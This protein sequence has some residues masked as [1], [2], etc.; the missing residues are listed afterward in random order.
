MKFTF[1]GTGT[2]QGVPVIACDCE[3]CQSED[4]YDKRLRTSGL[5]QSDQTTLV[6][7]TGPDFR[8]QMLVHRVKTLDA[9]VYTHT[10]RDHVAGLDDVR[11]YNFLQKRDM[12]VYGTFET[13][14]H[15][16]KE[17]YYIFESVNY[18]GVPKLELHEID[19]QPFEIG[20]ISLIPIPVMHGKMPVL[21]FR[22]GPFAYITDA[23]YI[24]PESLNA[25]E[26]VK[27]LVLNALR[28]TPH[29]SHFHLQ[30]AIEMTE[31]IQPEKAYFTHISH[32]MGPQQNIIDLLPPHIELAHDGLTL[33]W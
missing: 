27:T 24:P 2:S 21:G 32:L 29:H 6:F 30:A 16:R 9:V 8:E 28:L 15:L 26:G 11:S 33:E 22:I 4:P 3:T 14:K 10:H 13:F 17:F 7:D 19:H 18:P 23:N 25:L 31:K 1:L 5:L 12:P 20:D